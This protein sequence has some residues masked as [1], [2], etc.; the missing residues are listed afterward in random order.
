MR[1]PLTDEE[2]TDGQL[3]TNTV[4]RLA[5]FSRDGI[6]KGG[7]KPFFL[8]TGFHKVR[9]LTPSPVKV[10]FEHPFERNL[11]NTDFSRLSPTPRGLC[12]RSISSCTTAKKS[13]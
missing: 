10:F 5:N 9:T 11:T 4:Q 3:A 7:G 2:Q 12:P 1:S 6:G 8:A 13:V